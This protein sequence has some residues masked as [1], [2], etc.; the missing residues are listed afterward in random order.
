MGDVRCPGQ[1]MRYWAP[2]DI[3]EFPCPMCDT[4]IEFWKDESVRTCPKCKTQIR[5]PRMD[6]GCAKWCLFAKECLKRLALTEP[7]KTL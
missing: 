4:S 3:F 7:P 2:E 5:N 6:L 1:D